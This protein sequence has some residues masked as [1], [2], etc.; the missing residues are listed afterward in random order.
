MV[1]TDA[2]KCM[3]LLLDDPAV[4]IIFLNIGVFPKISTKIKPIWIKSILSLFRSFIPC[5]VKNE[6]FL[7]KGL[8]RIAYL[9]HF[10]I[11]LERLKSI[12]KSCIS[13]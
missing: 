2:P 13:L 11:Y 4:S 12:L 3:Y 7:E 6:V 9:T 5:L 1:I 8:V 10:F